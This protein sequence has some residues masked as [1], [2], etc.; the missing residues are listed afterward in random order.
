MNL[1]CRCGVGACVQGSKPVRTSIVAAI[2]QVLLW[3]SVA[4]AVLAY[5]PRLRVAALNSDVDYLKCIPDQGRLTHYYHFMVACLIPSVLHHGG[6]PSAMLFC[7][8]TISMIQI[9][10]ISIC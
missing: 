10:P 7:V 2:R 1:L 8:M 5:L 9:M 3:T 4:T 6:I